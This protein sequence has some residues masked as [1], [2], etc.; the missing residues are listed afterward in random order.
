MR[1]V[2][3]GGCRETIRVVEEQRGVFGLSNAALLAR[4]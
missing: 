4:K 3:R 1:K 2:W